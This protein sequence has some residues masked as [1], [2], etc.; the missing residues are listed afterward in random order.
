MHEEGLFCGIYLFCKG[1][2]GLELRS[3]PIFLKFGHVVP[4]RCKKKM[5]IGKDGKAAGTPNP[6][7]FLSWNF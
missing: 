2:T 5:L 3:N 4:E 7:V 6:K 1:C